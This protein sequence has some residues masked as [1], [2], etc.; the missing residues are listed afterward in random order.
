M[1]DVANRINAGL[2]PS[3]EEAWPTACAALK[4]CTG[5]WL[6]IHGTVATKEPENNH[7]AQ[8]TVQYNRYSHLLS[9]KSLKYN[10]VVNWIDYVCKRVLYLLGELNPT[11]GNWKVEVRHVEHV[12][13]YAPHVS[14]LVLDIE[15][16]PH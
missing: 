11:S 1:K 15:C 8:D 2:I 10:S 4:V 3:S 16:R 7:F 14:H 13:L 9:S 12:K 5:G 6:H